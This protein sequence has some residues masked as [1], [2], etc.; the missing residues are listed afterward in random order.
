MTSPLLRSLRSLARRR[1][2]N[3]AYHG[4]DE[5]RPAYD[6][7]N[8]CVTPA[9]FR[10]QLDL[11][12]AAGFEFLTVAELAERAGGGQPPPGLA[13]LSFDDGLEDNHRVVLP[14]LRELG[15][16]ATVYVTTGFIGRPNEWM[17]RQTR[18]MTED[19]LRE[20][21]R[22]G[23]ELGAHSVTHPDLS[24]L[25]AVDC[26]REVGESMTAVEAITGAPVR[27]FAYPFCRYGDDAIA[28]VRDAGLLAAVTCEGRGDWS[29]YT[30]K[31]ALITGVDGQ[32]S[33]VAKLWDVYEPAFESR[34]GRA[35]RALTRGA[36]ARVR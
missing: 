31:R 9:R 36:R 7:E 25:G 17:G 22:A 32:A 11:L 21:A 29:P 15:I 28:A 19:E 27:T 6:P 5:I 23:F 33:F 26:R 30:M 2:V 1:S 8:L 24:T 20:L 16:P 13:T 12:R 4:V 3:V 18:Y 34:P 35:F 10:A 14:I